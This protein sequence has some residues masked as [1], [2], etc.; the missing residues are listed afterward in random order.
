MLDSED[1]P[2]TI[3]KDPEQPVVTVPQHSRGRRLAV[4]LAAFVVVAVATAVTFFVYGNNQTTQHASTA[5]QAPQTSQAPKTVTPVTVTPKTP[6]Q[7]LASLPLGDGKV[8]TSA[9]KGYVYSC[10]TTFRGGGAQH[11][12][13][14]ISGATWNA[15]TKP[16]VNGSVAW[17]SAQ[18]TFTHTG[19]SRIIVGNG[20]PTDG[21]TTGIFPIQAGTTAYQYDT[22]PNHIMTQQL[23]FTLPADPVQTTT[24]NCVSMGQVG[25]MLDGVALFNALDDGGRDAVAHEIQDTCAGHPQMNGLYHYHGMSSCIKNEDANSTLVGYAM[26]GFGIYSDRD[27][28]GKQYTSADLDECHGTTSQITWDGHVVAMYHYVLTHDYPYTIGCFRGTPV[29]A[30]PGR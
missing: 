23:S 30:Q 27:A 1:E 12:G 4:M 25:Y 20:L 16:T 8:S 13:S 18:V 17:P 3:P 28:S 22:N 5:P 11:S 24:P 15:T 19:G 9:Q 14:W 29:H 6:D 2:S 26:D 21:I 7:D 10:S